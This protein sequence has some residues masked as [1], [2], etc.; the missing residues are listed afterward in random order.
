MRVSDVKKDRICSKGYSLETHHAEQPAEKM[1]VLNE[2]V[3]YSLVLSAT[4]SQLDKAVGI[5]LGMNNN[6]FA[7]SKIH[8]QR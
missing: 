8:K 2:C 6:Y 5:L 7:V 3:A 1:N 4:V